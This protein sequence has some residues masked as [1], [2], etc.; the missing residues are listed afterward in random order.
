MNIGLDAGLDVDIDIVIDIVLDIDI[1]IDKERDQDAEFKMETVVEVSMD[2]LY[3]RRRWASSDTVRCRRRWSTAGGNWPAC[4][5][6]SSAADARRQRDTGAGAR[7]STRSTT[8]TLSSSPAARARMLFFVIFAD[9]SEHWSLR[10]PSSLFDWLQPF[11]NNKKNA[12]ICKS[13]MA[14][15]RSAHVHLITEA[16]CK[17]KMQMTS[18]LVSPKATGTY[19]WN[20]NPFLDVWWHFK[21]RK[22]DDK[23]ERKPVSLLEE[24]NDDDD[25][26]AFNNWIRKIAPFRSTKNDEGQLENFLF[27]LNKYKDKM[28]DFLVPPLSKDVWWRSALIR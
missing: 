8:S 28:D 21:A 27:S 26:D 5:W 23:K 4:T 17:K 25:R 22:K 3:R 7:P 12:K 9:Q 20:W 14:C 10:R 2:D 15:C 16:E 18:V 6:E 1:D 19:H 13:T 24:K 11:N